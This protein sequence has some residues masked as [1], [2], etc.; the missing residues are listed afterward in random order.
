VDLD[1]NGFNSTASGVAGD[2]IVGT[3][4]DM[5]GQFHALLWTSR[6]VVD[7]TPS[8][9]MSAGAAATDGVQQ[10]GQGSTGGESRALLWS[11]TASSAVDLHPAALG[12]IYSSG[13]SGVGGGQ[14]V[15]T[16]LVRREGPYAPIRSHALLWTGSPESVVDLHPCG[17]DESDALAVAAG[18]QVGV[19]VIA[20]TNLTRAL[21]WNGTADSVVDLHAFL[22]AGFWSSK[23]RAIDASGNVLGSA[24]GHAILWVRQ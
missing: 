4:E 1:P 22:P 23:A 18:R 16:G 6:G 14:Q 8:G 19:G 20:G 21:L 7:L 5:N 11:G 9:F 2:E 12:Y 3:S 17:F 24:D 10:V 13:A 15:G